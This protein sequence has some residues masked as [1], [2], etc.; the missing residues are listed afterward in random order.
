MRPAVNGVTS[1]AAARST[2]RC[3]PREAST[4]SA[5]YC[6]I[7]VSS[8]AAPSDRVPR[9][10]RPACRQHRVHHRR[11]WRILLC[12]V[13]TN[14]MCS[15]QYLHNAIMVNAFMCGDHGPVPRR[16]RPGYGLMGPPT[17]VGFLL[18]NDLAVLLLR[19]H[20]ADVL[21]V[22]PLSGDGMA[23]WAR[24]VLTIYAACLPPRPR[25]PVHP[26]EGG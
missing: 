19:E 2:I 21:G 20:L 9:D 16:A 11:I 12:R 22:D 23:R 7:V 24:E 6:A 8:A 15:C 4:T 5:R 13:L 3:G 14:L 1:S 25:D 10:Q 26:G 17:R 18:A